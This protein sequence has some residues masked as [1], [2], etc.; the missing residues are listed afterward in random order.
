MMALRTQFGLD[1]T[2]WQKRYGL[3]FFMQYKNV[4]KKYLGTYLCFE[5]NHLFPTEQ[6][7]EILNTILVDFLSEN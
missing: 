4:L 6:G 3:D 5:K 1:V 2:A 7:M